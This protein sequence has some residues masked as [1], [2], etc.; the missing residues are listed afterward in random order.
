MEAALNAVGSRRRSSRGSGRGREW[1]ALLASAAAA[2]VLPA[3]VRAQSDRLGQ[4][5]LAVAARFL[6]AWELVRWSSVGADG[7]TTFPFGENARGQISYTP[8]GRMSAHLM[9]P[10]DDP[11]QAPPQHLSYWGTY[12]VD[13]AAGTITHRV[14]GAD[15]ANWI[16]TDQVRR[17]RFEGDDVLVLSLGAQDLVWRR[18]R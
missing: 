15:R 9:R 16:G 11:S 1:R 14:L 3:E 8:N 2:L 18:A 12:D 4:E 7:R 13:A 17:F 10:P 5:T 6:G